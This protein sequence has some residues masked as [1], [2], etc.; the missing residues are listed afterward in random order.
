MIGTDVI[1]ADL[2]IVNAT[3]CVEQFIRD[4]L[5][6][7]HYPERRFSGRGIVIA[8]GG[9]RLLINAWVAI[10]MLRHV[11]C[12]L[13]IECWYLGEDEY[14]A[15]WEALVEPFDVRCIDAFQVRKQFPH[16][17]LRGWELKPYAIQHSAYADVILL[18]ADNIAIRDPTYLFDS[19]YYHDYGAVFW[20]DCA[21]RRLGRDQPAW[22]VFGNIPYQDEPEFES[23][24]IVLDKSR[25]W[26]A[27]EL[28]H[29]YMQNSANFYFQYVQG[30]KEVFHLAWRRLGQLYAMPSRGIEVLPGVLCQHDFDGRRIFQHRNGRKWTFADNP[31]THGFEYEAEC[32]QFIQELSVNWSPAALTLPVDK[33]REAISMLDGCSF[34]YCRVGFDQRR[35]VFRG[36]GTFAAGGAACETYWTIRDGKMRIATNDGHLIMNLSP[37]DNGF[38]VGRWLMHERMPIVL[39]PTTPLA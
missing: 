28:C 8:A 23:G 36:D 30:D 24:Q 13:P 20:P 35:L 33:D 5:P 6:S 37:A 1:Q 16:A 11:G 10:R 18:D 27:L 34:D 12:E 19:S 7:R 21:D 3:A 39:V 32:R 29:W 26:A 15:A 2:T 31:T 38:W 17:Q 9:P 22:L 4:E 25:C 14:N